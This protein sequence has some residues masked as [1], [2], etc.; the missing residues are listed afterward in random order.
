[1]THRLSTLTTYRDL[2]LGGTAFGEG[3]A[4]FYGKR[5]KLRKHSTAREILEVVGPEVWNASF[6]FAFVRNPFA[7]AYSIYRFLREWREWKGSEQM[8]KYDSFASFVQSSF[9]EGDGPDRML[10]P[11]FFWV[12]D[13]PGN[14]IIKFVGRVEKLHEDLSGI[15]KQIGVDPPTDEAD[16]KNQRTEEGEWR[17]AYQDPATVAKIVAKYR[18]DFRVFGYEP[19]PI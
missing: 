15:F 18:V 19:N 1:M 9:F 16:R 12:R 3:I 6:T 13:E 5:F 4:P 8:D 11:Q 2:E 17:K 10:R 14:S 7:R